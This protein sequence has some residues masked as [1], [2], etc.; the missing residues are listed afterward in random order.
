M[1][2][3]LGY[4]FSGQNLKINDFLQQFCKKCGSKTNQIV[5]YDNHSRNIP[6]SL[7]PHCSDLCVKCLNGAPCN[8]VSDRLI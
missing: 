7:K 1:S 2:K 8:Y 5:Y 6:D 3:E 4:P